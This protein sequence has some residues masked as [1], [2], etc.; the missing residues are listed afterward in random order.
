MN[1]PESKT[2]HNRIITTMLKYVIHLTIVNLLSNK[3]ILL[4]KNSSINSLIITIVRLISMKAKFELLGKNKSDDKL[5][6][7]F[8]ITLHASSILGSL[9]NI[10]AVLV[11]M[12]VIIILKALM[13]PVVLFFCRLKIFSMI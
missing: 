12:N 3:V 5:V 7:I 11:R 1:C 4:G 13:I 8:P 6:K 10:H 2:P 9:K